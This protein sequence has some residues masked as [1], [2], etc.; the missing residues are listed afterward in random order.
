[1]VRFLNYKM[2]EVYVE[3][4]K[5]YDAK[6]FRRFGVHILEHYPDGEIV[7]IWDNAKRHHSKLLKDMLD[8]NS[9]LHLEFLLPCSPDLNKINKL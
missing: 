3:E 8:A 6:V 2:D 9:W 4:H 5:R 1:M 7:M